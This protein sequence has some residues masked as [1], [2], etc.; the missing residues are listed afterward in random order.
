[1]VES[2]R[3]NNASEVLR[4]G[5][6]LLEERRACAKSKIAELRRLV[7]EGRL[8]GPSEEAG[9][10]FWRGWKPNTRRWRTNKPDAADELIFDRRAE[11]D[12]EEIG[13][14][15]ARDNPGRRSASFAK[16]ASIA[17]VWPDFRKRHHSARVR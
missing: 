9:R 11:F 5:L 14:Y 8:S 10:H 17:S 16:S 7:E 13:D 2:G 6:R 12:L 4:D 1:M 3:Y 15:I